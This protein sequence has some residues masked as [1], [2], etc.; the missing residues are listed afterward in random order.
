MLF[1][2]A[3]VSP[4]KHIL[5]YIFDCA[6]VE[7]LQVYFRDTVNVLNLKTFYYLIVQKLCVRLYAYAI[8]HVQI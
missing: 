2:C 5:K 8:V 1:Y 7:L 4:T 6:E 3:E